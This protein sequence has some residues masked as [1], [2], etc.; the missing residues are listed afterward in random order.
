MLLIP[1]FE[2][3]VIL[4]SSFRINLFLSPPHSAVLHCQTPFK[5]QNLRALYTEEKGL[6]FSPESKKTIWNIRFQEMRLNL[7]DTDSRIIEEILVSIELIR[8][9]STTA[10]KI[11]T[12]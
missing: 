4:E 1:A 12:K 9:G 3:A 6:K 7:Y 5:S 2:D 11:F 8:L 10:E